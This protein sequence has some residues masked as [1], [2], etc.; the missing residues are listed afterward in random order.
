[1]LAKTADV[2]DTAVPVADA[3]ARTQSAAAVSVKRD[4]RSAG[5]DGVAIAWLVLGFLLL[6]PG[7]ALTLGMTPASDLSGAGLLETL[8]RALKEIQF[9]TGLRFWL[10]VVGAAAMALLLIY[11]LRKAFPNARLPG[12]V[13]GWFRAHILIGIFAPVAVLYHASFGHGASN[14]NV[15]LWSM[16]AVAASGLAGHFIHRRASA[17]F[18]RQRE[19]ARRYVDAVLASLVQHDVHGTFYKAR[20]RISDSFD[21]IDALLLAARQSF[22]RDLEARRAL[23]MAQSDMSGGVRWIVETWGEES[24]SSRARIDEHLER[25]QRAIDT[26][27]I[28]AKR[29]AKWAR[30]EHMWSRWRL[31]HVP[32]YVVMLVAIGLHVAAVW[33]TGSPA[34]SAA[35]DVGLLPRVPVMVDIQK[36]RPAPLI[37]P[38]ARSESLDSVETQLSSRRSSDA[39]IQPARRVTG[40]PP[41]GF[42]DEDGRSA[43]VELKRLAEAPAEVPAIPK[44]RSLAEQIQAWKTK[45]QSGAFSH[46]AEET[47][48]A[49][50]RRHLKVDCTSCHK[51]A[52]SETPSTQPRQCVACHKADDTHRGRRP[53]CVQCHSPEGWSRL[54]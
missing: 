47:G 27:F 53:N 34:S 32:V 51:V 25:A 49:L 35:L 43:S 24:G 8:A 21:E 38:S 29:T 16:L 2:E 11:P 48:F 17:G 31:F 6:L 36:V 44:P 39:T 45:M 20:V 1:M 12:S 19:A 46:S 13:A 3:G 10:G 26:Y 14:A 4:G 23:D 18:Y 42:K 37:L 7:L 5:G 41:P 40:A 28:L 22:R 50:T 15:A 33:P 30:R 52:L 9:G 54:K